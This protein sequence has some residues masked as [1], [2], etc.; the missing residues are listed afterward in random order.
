MVKV[1]HIKH[2]QCLLNR[3]SLL[4]TEKVLALRL[5]LDTGS[6]D[7]DGNFRGRCPGASPTFSLTGFPLPHLFWKRTFW[8]KLHR[9]STG[10][11]SK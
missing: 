9:H 6:D 11:V 2:G 7:H 4:R 10:Q 3:V 5:G 8:D 1:T